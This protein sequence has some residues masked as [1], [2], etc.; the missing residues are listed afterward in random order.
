MLGETRYGKWVM[1]AFTGRLGVSVDREPIAAKLKERAP[2]TLAITLEAMLMSWALAVPI[3]V[4]SAW[5]RGRPVDT[6]TAGVLF[7]LY[8]M[9]TFW[10]AELLRR[11]FLGSLASDASVGTARL[12]LPVLALTLAALATLSR[13]QRA[14]LLD[15][16]GQDYVRTARAK[17]LP[18]WRVVVVHALRNAL[19]PTVTLAG[20]QLPALL[21]GAVVVEETFSVPGLGYETV[22]AVEARDAPWLIC[23]VVAAA[24]ATTVGLIVSDVVLGVLD[25]RVREMLLAG[26][27]REVAS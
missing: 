5:R 8:S 19:L 6:V 24:I 20:L 13:Y 15:A 25:P 26:P 9:P 12:V 22:R 2:V 23:I 17:G 1:R 14:A 21:G 7:A 4:V 27:R 18:G 11:T 3:A 10:A 16:L